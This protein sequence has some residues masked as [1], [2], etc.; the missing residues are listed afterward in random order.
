M[1]GDEESMLVGTWKRLIAVDGQQGFHFL[2]R[3][4]LGTEELRAAV[5]H[6][7]VGAVRMLARNALP[8]G[9]ID[10]AGHLRHV[11]VARLHPVNAAVFDFDDK[12]RVA[13][14]VGVKVIVGVPKPDKVDKAAVAAVLPYGKSEVEV[15]EGGLEIMND[16]GTN[17]TVMANAAAVVYLDI[18]ES[19]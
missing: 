16:E 11:Q 12:D 1:A 3:Q 8:L 7:D 2:L 9:R 13:V 19:A 10:R 17:L 6:D 14:I 18:Q 15:V 4:L 5:G